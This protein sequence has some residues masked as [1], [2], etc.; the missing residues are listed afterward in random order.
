VFHLEEE[1]YAVLQCYVKVRRSNA[2]DDHVLGWGLSYTLLSLSNLLRF[3]LV[4]EIMS[5]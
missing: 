4:S 2:I 1:E 5:V 3:P